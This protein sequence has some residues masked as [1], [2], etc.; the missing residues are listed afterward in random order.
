MPYKDPE[1]KKAYEKAYRQTPEY[2]AYEKAR[3]QTPEYKA[4]MKALYHN[5]TAANNIFRIIAVNTAFEK[6]QKAV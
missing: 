5:H 3:S 4:Y 2:K 1:K 6:G